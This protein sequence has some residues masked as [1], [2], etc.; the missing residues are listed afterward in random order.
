MPLTYRDDIDGLRAIA[1]LAVVL[2]H[3]GIPYFS[4][5]YIG[6]DIFFVISGF[7]ITS[8]I[9]RELQEGTFTIIR[10]Y[11]RRVRRILPAL[12]GMTLF[13][14]VVCAVLFEA[15]KFKAFG[16]SLAATMLFVSN[17][18]FWKEA[19]Y[20][21]A[22]SRLKP[23]LHTWSLAVEEQFYIVFP[24]LMFV[25]MKYTK[26]YLSVILLI[27]SLLSFGFAAYQVKVNATTA[28]Y[29]AH[30]RAWE[31]L[32]GSL[33]AVGGIP[34]PRTSNLRTALAVSGLAMILI[35]IFMYNEKTSFPGISALPP[36]IGTVLLI[37]SGA[38][39]KTWMG[40]LLGNAPLTFI[41]KISYSLYLW[42]WPIIIFAGVYLIRPMTPVEIAAAVLLTF[43]ISI[44]SWMWIETP[45]RKKGIISTKQV[46]TFAASSMLLLTG[47]AGIV[48]LF[49]GFP[50][51][52]GDIQIIPDKTA[53][54]WTLSD[55][56]A[57]AIDT[58][59]KLLTCDIGKRSDMPDFLLWGDSHTSNYAKAI[60]EAALDEGVSG[61]I[62][63]SHG[64]PPLI[65]MVPNPQIGD[66]PCDKHN[67]MVLDF[68]EDN[69]QINTVI[70]AVRFAFWVEGTRYKQEEG[71]TIS[72]TSSPNE[73]VVPGGNET[74]FRIGFEELLS[75][76]R[77]SGRNVIVIAPVPE[78][79]YD[80]P[81]ATFVATRTRRDV[82]EIIA[83]TTEEFL[84]RNKV[85]FGILEQTQEEY[86]FQVIEPWKFLCGD[87]FCKVAVDGIPLYM[88]DDHMSV[89]GSELLAPAFEEIFNLNQR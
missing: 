2:N 3:A 73:P 72:I 89:F 75:R 48:Y 58:M 64:C 21:D 74:N 32:L 43:A 71:G 87:G 23:L 40:V 39:E 65:G 76:L 88:D 34:Q 1:V 66:I 62:A 82:N 31:L 84:E 18:N 10:F 60:H 53:D 69:P 16:K 63:Y 38:G 44:A 19:G 8:I 49:D 5:G 41:G 27:L 36:V 77:S 56:N 26:R 11:E 79:G 20:F 30:L 17:I 80:V 67:E 12:T 78:I 61:V 6:V 52:A 24:W 85:V 86:G 81:S 51:R 28:F 68:L 70:L 55:C 22:P 33:I 83:P 46:Y 7:L 45:F 4:G 35:P 25:L 47:A 50:Q 14:L 59:D 42:H 13:T 57:N 54:R 37:Y 9:Y 15:D 29:M